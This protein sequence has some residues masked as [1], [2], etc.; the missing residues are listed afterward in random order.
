M[1]GNYK[2]FIAFDLGDTIMIEETEEKDADGVTLRADLIPGLEGLLRR[3]ANEGVLLGLIADTMIGTYK[4]VLKQHG[5]YDLFQVFSIS[6]ELG[7]RKPHPR[8]FN[9]AKEQ[10]ERKGFSGKDMLM[11]GNNYDR[12][13]VGGKLAGYSTCWFYWNDRYPYDEGASAADGTVTTAAD[14]SDWITKWSAERH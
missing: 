9:Y 14:L 11:V 10:A 5:L 8:M 2:V 3:L 12:D 1:T 13:I 4:N 7:V 6:D